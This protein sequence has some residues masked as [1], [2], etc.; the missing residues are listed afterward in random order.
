MVREKN[1]SFLD[2]EAGRELEEG[3]DQDVGLSYEF[4]TGGWIWECNLSWVKL[5]KWDWPGIGQELPQAPAWG[6]RD[7]HAHNCGGSPVGLRHG[8]K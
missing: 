8:V 1:S 3:L 6:D 7:T 5:T 2:L 4:G